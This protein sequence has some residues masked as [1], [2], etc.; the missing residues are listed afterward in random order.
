MSRTRR[1]LLGEGGAG[2]LV[3]TLLVL[4]VGLVVTWSAVRDIRAAVSPAPLACATLL[5]DPQP[6]QWV[7]LEGCRLEFSSASAAWWSHRGAPAAPSELLVPVTAGAG[8]PVRLV[9][10]TSEA[11]LLALGSSLDAVAPDAVD[12]TLAARA[13]E[14]APLL[15]PK[16]LRGRVTRLEGARSSPTSEDGVMVLDDGRRARLETLGR[17]VLGLLV[18]LVAFW[19]V[20]R[21]FQLERELGAL[22]RAGRTDPTASSEPE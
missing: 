12:A 14:V 15:T 20:A 17:L 6:G 21:R 18:M 3:G 1:V 7:V 4:G 2:A 11:A 22:T 13:A 10:A 9:L 5:E 8:G 19:P 16:A